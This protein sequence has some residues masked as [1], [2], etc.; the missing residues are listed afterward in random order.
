MPK[1]ISKKPKVTINIDHIASLA[2]LTLSEEEKRIL[3]KQLEETIVYVKRL[4]KLDTQGILP[5]SQV[6]NLE[7]ITRDD[8]AGPSL[9]QDE[10]LKNAK[11]THNGFIMTKAIL[12][13]Q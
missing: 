10:A 11:S 6:T 4:E 12:E 5:T 1:V 3:T 8:I 13:E 9:S 7:N 2:S